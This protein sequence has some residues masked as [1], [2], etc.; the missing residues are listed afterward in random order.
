MLTK[1]LVVYSSV[2][3]TLLTTVMLASSAA[4]KIQPRPEN[5]W[6]TGWAQR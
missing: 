5:L 4:A 6:V 1:I 2:L 3:T